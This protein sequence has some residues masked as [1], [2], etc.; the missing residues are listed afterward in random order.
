MSEKVTI[1]DSKNRIRTLHEVELAK[2]RH[3]MCY[4]ASVGWRNVWF[5]CMNLLR[6]FYFFT[7]Q[8]VFVCCGK[9]GCILL[10]SAR[11]WVHFMGFVR[12]LWVHIAPIGCCY[13]RCCPNRITG[14]LVSTVCVTYAPF[15][16]CINP[17]EELNWQQSAN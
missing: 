7:L 10:A 13:R 2:M 17:I 8:K 9:S 12:S 15:L 4:I 6:Y 14:A 16:F 11:V 1:S 5:Q 3:S